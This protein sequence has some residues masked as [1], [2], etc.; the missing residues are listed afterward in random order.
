MTQSQKSLKAFN[1]GSNKSKAEQ[2]LTSR[3]ALAAA[4]NKVPKLSMVEAY[5]QYERA[6]ATNSREDKVTIVEARKIRWLLIYGTLQWLISALRA[7]AEVTDTETDYPLCCLVTEHPPWQSSLDTSDATPMDVPK[8]INDTISE[9][10]ALTIQPDCETDE[11]PYFAP[12]NLDATPVLSRHASVERSA[13]SSAVSDTSRR[14]LRRISVKSRSFRRNAPSNY[15]DMDIY[16]SGNNI[17]RSTTKSSSYSRST[18]NS[19]L[20]KSS[21]SKKSSIP[22]GAAPDASL[23]QS[24]NLLEDLA[25][26][27]SKQS[28][29]LQLSHTDI[30]RAQARTPVLESS[31]FDMLISPITPDEPHGSSSDSTTSI[32][33]PFWSDKASYTS[34]KSSTTD[35]HRELNKNSAEDYRLLAGLKPIIDTRIA[36]PQ[37]MD[38]WN[39]AS[40]ITPGPDDRFRFSFNN[41]QSFDAVEVALARLED[42]AAEVAE[43]SIGVAVSGTPHQHAHHDPSLSAPSAALA[44][45]DF[46]ADRVTD[47]ATPRR[48]SMSM[49]A[50][51]LAPSY[52]NTISPSLPAKKKV[53]GFKDIFSGFSLAPSESQTAWLAGGGGAGFEEFRK[54][55]ITNPVLDSIPK[56]IT[57]TPTVKPT[58]NFEEPERGRKRERRMSFWRR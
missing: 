17:S 16:A 23:L 41:T 2:H 34:S 21:H 54:N 5:M 33:S 35:E 53:S 39:S 47:T 8:A 50:T 9:V 24:S 7:P 43:S 3:A 55:R 48:R 40:S 51:T 30:N 38:S 31:Q 25:G 15:P 13:P 27:A 4:T 57:S 36:G 52:T 45:D 29:R 6:A 19:S 20:Y 22:E 44:F 10:Q 1:L 14:S 49:S 18:T 32:D 12:T 37:R 28:L 11:S 58:K 46:T 56:P 42:S 26:G